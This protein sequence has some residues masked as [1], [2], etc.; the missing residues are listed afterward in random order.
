LSELLD[1]IP[2]GEAVD[3]IDTVARRFPALVIGEVLAIPRG[4]GERLFH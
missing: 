4:D 1:T 3:F 2:R